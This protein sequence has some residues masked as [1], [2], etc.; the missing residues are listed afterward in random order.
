MD[1]L[2]HLA[3]LVL[4]IAADAIWPREGEAPSEA[5]AWCWRYW[6]G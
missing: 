1:L 6:I 4:E 5:I 3:T 2:I